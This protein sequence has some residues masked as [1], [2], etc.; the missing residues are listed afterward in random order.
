MH[1]HGVMRCGIHRVSRVRGV[2]YCPQYFD[3]KDIIGWRPACFVFV[4]IY[5]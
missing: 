4:D 1:A 2:L 3:E 5:W